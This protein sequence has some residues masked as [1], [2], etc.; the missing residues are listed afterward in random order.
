MQLLLWE[1]TMDFMI[2]IPDNNNYY[3]RFS[4]RRKC[5]ALSVSKWSTKHKDLVPKKVDIGLQKYKADIF[6][7]S[8]SSEW[9]LTYLHGR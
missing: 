9:I 6:S 3:E 7:I 2:A 8:P 5:G 1:Q 4:F